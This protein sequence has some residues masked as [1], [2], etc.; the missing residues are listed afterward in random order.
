MNDLFAVRY[1][2]I[3]V[4]KRYPLRISRGVITGK[5]NLFVEVDSDG[6]TGLGEMCPGNLT[7]AETA[8]AGQLDVQR[9]LDSDLAGLSIH[10]IWERGQELQIAPCALAALDMALWDWLAK[11]AGM[12]LYRL[13]GLGLPRVPTSITIGIN[14]PEVIAERVP[15]MLA[16]TGALSLKVKLGAPDGISADQAAY[17]AARAAAKPRGVRLRVDANGGWNVNDARIMLRWLADRDCDYVEQPLCVEDDDRLA[18]LY[19]DRPLPIYVD[20]SCCTKADIPRWAHMVDGCNLKL[21]KCGGITEALR[22]VA[23]ARAHGL[24]TMIGCNGESSVSI[25]AGAAL[26]SLF[27]H[28]D[29]DSHLNLDPDPA[30]GVPLRDGIVMPMDRIGHGGRLLSC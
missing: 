3:F 20:E 1:Q 13:L 18:E 9:L 6:I 24:G 25:A 2:H 19:H 27:D 17:L 23:T 26:G 7:G 30:D 21:M 4:R 11:R 5:T 8:E 10:E 15:E 22:I 29:L 28:I 16:D 14:P 12:P